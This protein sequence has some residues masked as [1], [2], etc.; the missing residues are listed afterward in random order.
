V[1][2]AAQRGLSPELMEFPFPDGPVLDA[3]VTADLTTGP[4]GER[5]NYGERISEILGRY[6][7]DDPVHQTW[8]TAGPILAKSV[9]RTEARLAAGSA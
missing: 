1:Y 2:E 4:A 5:L 6:P 9:R 7:V 8:L 3:L